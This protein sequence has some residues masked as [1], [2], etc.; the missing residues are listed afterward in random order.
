MNNKLWP[1]L[2]LEKWIETYDMLHL[3]S[4]I[5]GKIKLQFVPFKNHWWNVVLYPSITGLTTGIIPYKEKYFEIDFN[6][7]SHKIIFRFND[8]QS[9]YINLQNGTIKDY[10]N[11]IKEKLLDLDCI[12]DLWPIPVEMEQRIPFNEDNKMRIYNEEY[13]E[14]FQ[15]IILQASKV[16]E[17]F[18]A[19]YTGKSSPVH[20]F[21][22]AFDL[23]VTFF[24]G[25]PAPEHSGAPNVGKD[26]M[27]K[28]YNAELASFG[29]WPGKGFGEPAF[30]SYSY[31][32]PDKYK[33]FKVEPDVAYYN[34][35]LG[36][37]ILPYQIV[38]KLKNP[39]KAILDFFK[40]SYRATKTYGDWDSSLST[41]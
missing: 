31:P 17:I 18:R 3:I 34:K 27:V 19:G 40:S 6:L 28:A 20:F 8:G 11:Q 24:S 4:Q 12:I 9:D 1:E 21:W 16:M 26:V 36:E 37:F 23:A 15:Q 13:A 14:N 25:K 39:D 30:Y 29:F 38:Q 7:R 35:D 5:I 41:Y 10:Y 2:P 22:G 33:N 32:E